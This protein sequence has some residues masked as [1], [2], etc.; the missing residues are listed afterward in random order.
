MRDRLGLIPRQLVHELF[1][2]GDQSQ[3]GHRLYLD[4]PVPAEQQM[5]GEAS[6]EFGPSF[7]TVQGFPGA[8][9]QAHSR[10][11]FDLFEFGY[12]LTR[13]VVPA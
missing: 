4:Y 9:C 11:R 8:H 10:S 13:P 3:W 6:W 7:E 2:Q 5:S 12:L 1:R